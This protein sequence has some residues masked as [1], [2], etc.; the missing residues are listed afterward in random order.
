M[1][2]QHA[3]AN[4]RPRCR[5]VVTSPWPEKARKQCRHGARYILATVNLCYCHHRRVL[6]GKPIEFVTT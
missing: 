6:A 4:G 2:G 5:A 1:T 3:L